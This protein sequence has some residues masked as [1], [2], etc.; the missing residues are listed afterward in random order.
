MQTQTQN[1][2]CTF[3]C[4]ATCTCEFDFYADG[5]ECIAVADWRAAV[6]NSGISAGADEVKDLI[7]SAPAC[8]ATHGNQDDFARFGVLSLAARAGVPIVE[9]MDLVVAA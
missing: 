1:C 7:A 8:L 3:N 4:Y 2:A 9:L 5:P 6:N